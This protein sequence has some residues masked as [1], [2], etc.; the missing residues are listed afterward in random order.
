MRESK[1]TVPDLS[2]HPSLAHAR[3]IEAICRPLQ[4]LNINYFSHVY[5]DKDKQFSA[6]CSNPAY[7]E[8]YI[9]NRCYNLDIHMADISVLGKYIIW[10]TLELTGKT[11]V[12]NQIAEQFGIAH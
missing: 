3:D 12:E 11:A 6:I 7:C 1:M 5:I 10:D 4:K 9:K 8:Y 2:I